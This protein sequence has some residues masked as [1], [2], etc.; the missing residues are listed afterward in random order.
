M[1]KTYHRLSCDTP[2]VKS[3]Y[4]RTL[5]REGQLVAI[6]GLNRIQNSAAV[7]YLNSSITEAGIFKTC[8]ENISR[9]CLEHPP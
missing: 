5:F 2:P 9:E 8:M 7:P 4:Y 6:Q 3:V 1:I